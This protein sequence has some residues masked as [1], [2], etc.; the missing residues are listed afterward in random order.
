MITYQ[1]IDKEDSLKNF[2]TEKEQEIK[3]VLKLNEKL[4]QEKVCK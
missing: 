4:E 2:L 3:D 1:N